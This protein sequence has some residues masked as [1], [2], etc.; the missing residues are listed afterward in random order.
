MSVQRA[1]DHLWLPDD[2]E[3]DL[4][5]SD[6]HQ[7]AIDGIYDA[8]VDFA[9]LAGL[10]WHVGNQLTLAAEM[11]NGTIWRPSPDIMV[12][13]HAGPEPRKEMA[14]REEGPPALVVEVASESTWRHDVNDA[15]GKAAGYLAIGVQDYL[16]FDPTAAYLGTSCRGWQQVDG[17]PREW[18]P[19]PDGSYRCRSL[20][21]AL[22]PEGVFLRV[23]D[24]SG[25]PIASREERLQEIATLRA[26]LAQLRR[27]R[28][29]SESQ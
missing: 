11:P 26:E 20:A 25:R 1:M 14:T 21:I 4:V 3:E 17:V 10:P 7:R 15:T 23:C 29:A 24:P 27:Q 13:P 6:C 18:Q 16:V 22:R 12:H 19:A 9:F 2:T 28:D 8:L 5:G